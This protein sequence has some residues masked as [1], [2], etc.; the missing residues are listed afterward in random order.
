[1]LAD[2]PPM[3]ANAP[4]ML[5]QSSGNARQCSANAPPMLASAPPMLRQCSPMLRQCSP[6]LAVRLNGRSTVAMLDERF[7][8]PAAVTT[9]MGRAAEADYVFLSRLF[10]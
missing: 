5:R 8:C 3:L 4:P 7:G 2:A 9:T 1:M 10:D 6:M